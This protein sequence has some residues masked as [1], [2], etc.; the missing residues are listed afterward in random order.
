V[1]SSLLAAQRLYDSIITLKERVVAD[2]PRECHV[3]YYEAIGGIH[4]FP[5]FLW[6]E[7]ERT[8]ILQAVSKW[9]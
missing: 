1:L 9:L 3:T 7:A 6:Y 4:A 8:D 5:S 2:M